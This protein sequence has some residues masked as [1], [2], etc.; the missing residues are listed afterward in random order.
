M[1][2]E[3]Y[4][5]LTKADALAIVAYLRSLPPVQNQVPGPFGP[6]QQPTV[7]VMA[8]IPGNVYSSLPPPPPPPPGAPPAPAK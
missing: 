5:N 6:T 3:A 7:F 4:A 2:Y 8:V 1:P